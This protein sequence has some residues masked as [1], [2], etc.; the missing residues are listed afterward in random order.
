MR[1]AEASGDLNPIHTDPEAARAAG[2]PGIILHGTCTLAF[3]VSAL[4]NGM[5]DADPA[6][7]RAL[8]VRFSRP[9]LVPDRVT[10]EVW[11]S[12]PGQLCFEA[13][14]Q[15]GEVVLSRGVAQ[16]A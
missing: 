4:V 5:L 16:V 1:Y 7:L 9:V 13:S 10:T 11:T 3:A 12:E 15:A 2:L 6:R 14:N 8:A